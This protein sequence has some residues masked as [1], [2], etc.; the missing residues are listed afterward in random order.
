MGMGLDV[1][2]VQAIFNVTM[3]LQIYQDFGFDIK[4][5][6]FSCDRKLMKLMIDPVIHSNPVRT[7]KHEIVYV[8]KSS[9]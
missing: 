2:N 3:S 6:N 5:L 8:D 9:V 4:R 7:P 1:Q